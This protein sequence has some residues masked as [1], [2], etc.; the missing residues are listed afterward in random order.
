MKKRIQCSIYYCNSACNM[1][2]FTLPSLTTPSL[3]LTSRC[4]NIEAYEERWVWCAC[5]LYHASRTRYSHS[6]LRTSL[7]H[8]GKTSWNSW[9]LQNENFGLTGIDQAHLNNSHTV[10]PLQNLLTAYITM[11]ILQVTCTRFSLLPHI[12]YHQLSTFNPHLH[13]W[14]QRAHHL[15]HVT[16]LIN[17]P[18]RVGV[19]SLLLM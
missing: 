18:T 4:Q 9:W 16:K 13:Q 10:L 8:C 5:V 14:Q 2:S 1:I 11:T 6:T 17:P 3:H 12:C 15:G 7:F 19:H